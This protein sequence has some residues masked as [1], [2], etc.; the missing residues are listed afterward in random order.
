MEKDEKE[1]YR[2]IKFM[3]CEGIKYWNKNYL[4]KESK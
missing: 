4:R 1:L 2:G 3:P